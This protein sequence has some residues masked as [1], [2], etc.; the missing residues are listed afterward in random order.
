MEI[1]D[2]SVPFLVKERNYEML[3]YILEDIQSLANYPELKLYFNKI[4][5]MRRNIF[6]LV[7]KAIDDACQD[8]KYLEL[9]H[10]RLDENDQ[11]EP[12]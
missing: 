10:N 11:K 2:K 3:N 8:L 5:E 1:K 12:N 9:G 7:R 4:N 6:D